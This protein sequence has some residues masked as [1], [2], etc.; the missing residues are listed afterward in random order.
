MRRRRSYSNGYM[1]ILLSTVYTRLPRRSL[2]DYLTVLHNL[3]G[4]LKT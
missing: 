3:S 1:V 4:I 2:E